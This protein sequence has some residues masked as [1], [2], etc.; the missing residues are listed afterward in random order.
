MNN[1]NIISFEEYRQKKAGK[2]Y[3]ED[4]FT[5]IFRKD[6]RE[7]EDLI[8][9]YLFHKDFNKHK[10]FVHSLFYEN[11][12]QKI[13]NPNSGY[14]IGF[15]KKAIENHSKAMI[16]AVTWEGRDYILLQA[17][18]CTYRQLGEMVNGYKSRSSEETSQ[19]FRDVLLK[20]NKVI[21]IQ[22][23]SKMKMS[24][25][26]KTDIARFLI[27]ILDDAHFDGIFPSS[28]LIFIDY[29]DFLQKSWESIGTYL[30][31]LA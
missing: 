19:A 11:H 4:A 1:D 17:A 23:L 25:V 7:Q 26:E 8:N 20:T 12:I 6:L 22:E 28:D 16:D 24:A 9:W 30:T 27:K 3:R 2:N 21:I 5:A 29:A 10:L 18:G 14:V 13:P 31:V 15:N